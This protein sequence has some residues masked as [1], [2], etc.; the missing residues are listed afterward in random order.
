M[1]INIYSK[2]IFKDKIKYEKIRYLIFLKFIANIIKYFN[3]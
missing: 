3:I 2:N 1:K